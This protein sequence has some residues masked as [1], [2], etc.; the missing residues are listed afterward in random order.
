MSPRQFDTLLFYSCFCAPLSSH[1]WHHLPFRPRKRRKK[2]KESKDTY[3][4]CAYRIVLKDELSSW[5]TPTLFWHGVTTKDLLLMSSFVPFQV[6]VT[7]V[8]LDFSVLLNY[9][10]K[11]E[12]CSFMVMCAFVS[13]MGFALCFCGFVLSA[14][15]AACASWS[16]SSCEG[17]GACLCV[18]VPAV[19]GAWF[20]CN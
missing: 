14:P 6:H 9:G 20:H 2:G 4:S 7:H 17:W 8:L 18:C 19:W 5:K 15:A 10:S 13:R 16:A 11:K 3:W 1:Q 12:T